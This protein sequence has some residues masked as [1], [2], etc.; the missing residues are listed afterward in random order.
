VGSR[1]QT[2]IVGAA[3][4]WA[5]AAAAAAA[6]GATV[7]KVAWRGEKR[8]SHATK[9]R[10]AADEALLHIDFIAER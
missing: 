4:R 7:G 8:A 3:R 5:A 6:V 2:S 1:L 10:S 9:Q